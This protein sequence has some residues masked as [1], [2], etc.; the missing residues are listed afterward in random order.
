MAN[1]NLVQPLDSFVIVELTLE[2]DIFID[3]CYGRPRLD[4][5]LV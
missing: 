2:L 3:H 4:T 5:V 1:D